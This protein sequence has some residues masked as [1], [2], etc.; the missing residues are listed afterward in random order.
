MDQLNSNTHHQKGKHLSFEE[1]V[2]IQTR[3]KDNLSPNKIAAELGCSP[4]TV[5]N[6]IKHGTVSLYNGNVQRYKATSD[7]AFMK[8]IEAIPA[9]AAST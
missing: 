5:R 4:N 6:E 1:R 7:K 9:V 8:P 3:F 2:I